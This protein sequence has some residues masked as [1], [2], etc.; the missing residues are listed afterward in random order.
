MTGT[1]RKLLG[2][3]VEC[4]GWTADD[5]IQVAPATVLALEAQGYARVAR[6]KNGSV[7]SAS[8]TALGRAAARWGRAR[9]VAAD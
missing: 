5:F 7:D 8:L 1:Q 2:H 6:T 4:D 9:V 3:M